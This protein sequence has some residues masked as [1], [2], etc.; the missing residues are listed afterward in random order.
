MERGNGGMGMHKHG[1]CGVR[2]G[3]GKSPK[4]R[5]YMKREAEKYEA[6]SK[7]LKLKFGSVSDALA[8]EKRKS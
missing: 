4:F 2:Q 3:S 7:S 5:H 6:K 8:A 1:I